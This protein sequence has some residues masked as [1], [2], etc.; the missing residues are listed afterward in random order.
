MSDI[1]RYQLGLEKLSEVVGTAGQDAVSSLGDVGQY[2]VEFIFG[3]IY[4]REGLSLREREII[5]VAVLAALGGRD[6]QLRLHIGGALNVGLTLKEIEEVIIQ[7]IPY[8]GFPTA[9]NALKILKEFD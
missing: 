5:S 8:A 4:N 1:N 6:P 9:M 7:T 3:D 2:I